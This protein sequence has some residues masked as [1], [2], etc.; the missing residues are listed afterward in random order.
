M[1]SSI[2]KKKKRIKF[3]QFIMDKSYDEC[4]A[5]QRGIQESN[6]AKVVAAVRKCRMSESDTCF[7][8]L[9]V[10]C[11]TGLNDLI[12]VKRVVIPQVVERWG[13]DLPVQI[14]CADVVENEWQQLFKN[15]NDVFEK[16]TN[17]F[18]SAVGQSFTEQ[19]VRT[20]SVH[21]VLS[22]SCLHWFNEVPKS[23]VASKGV[24]FVV[25]DE[26]DV[27]KRDIRKLCDEMLKQFLAARFKELAPGGQLIATFDAETDS[28]PLHNFGGSTICVQDAIRVLLDQGQLSQTSLQG[29]FVKTASRTEAEIRSA[30]ETVDFETQEL[31]FANA[32][33]PYLDEYLRSRDEEKFGREIANA[34]RSCLAQE[35]VR[36]LTLNGCEQVDTVLD[37]IFTTCARLA[38]E[39]DRQTEYSTM[40]A[41]CT[42]WV[43]KK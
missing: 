38:S 8:V 16:Q 42:L 31:A 21:L 2:Q 13:R 33:C 39:K 10:G 20:G 18:V 3:L 9:L 43:S 41:V 26:S 34:M 11:A 37:L 40:G 6:E 22:F 4:S 14:I 29:Y 35:L 23:V 36:C 25:L 28:I 19:C 27:A 1:I 7:C 17:I 32:A 12:L 15:T 30:L 24:C 5:A